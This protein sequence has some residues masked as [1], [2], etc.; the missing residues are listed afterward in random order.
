MISNSLKNF[1]VWNKAIS[2]VKLSYTLVSKFPPYENFSLS[3]QV[4]RSCVSV[5]S[6]IAEGRLRKGNDFY[7]FISVA[8]GSLSE[9]QTQIIIAM[10]LSY[11]SKSDADNFLKESS[12]IMK[13]LNSILKHK[14]QT[15]TTNYKLE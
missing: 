5:A 9:L 1:I 2:L 7:Y 10:E 13:I 15:T 11:I 6:N 8:R 3:S 4:R 14:S 12:E